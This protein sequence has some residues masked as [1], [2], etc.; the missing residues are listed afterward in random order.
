MNLRKKKKLAA[1]VMGVG[2]NRVILNNA[3]LE[4][5][6]DAITRQDILDLIKDKAITLREVK[7]RTINEKKGRRKYGSIRKKIKRRKKHYAIKVRKHRNYISKLKKQNKI[8]NE[9]YNGLR[10]KIKQNL[11]K[12][13][14]HLISEAK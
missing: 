12:D 7:G 4:E 10:K 3:R 5:I 11:F 9:K 8:S 2:I 14:K 13:I 6:K 1:K